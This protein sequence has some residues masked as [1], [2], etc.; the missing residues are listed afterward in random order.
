M[1]SDSGICASAASAE[2]DVKSPAWEG[3]WLSLPKITG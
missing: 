1:I 2:A 3:P